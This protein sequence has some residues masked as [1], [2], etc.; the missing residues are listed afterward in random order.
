MNEERAI[1][2]FEDAKHYCEENHPEE[3]DW[4]KSISPEK[5]KHMKSKSFLM[6]YCWVVYVSGFRVATIEERFSDL[7]SAFKEFELVDLARMRSI[8][9]VLAVFNNERKAN[10]FLEGS[11]MIAKEGFSAFKKR[12]KE[13]GID[14]L[15]GL[16]GIGPITKYHLAKNIGLVDE[17][18]PDIWLARAAQE[19]SSTVQDLAV[20]D[21]VAFL[22]EKYSMS[23]HAV[24][25]ILWRYGVDKKL[26]L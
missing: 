26:G 11:K 4:A 1:K 21:L 9:P 19:C 18:K 25:V 12:L 15:E 22:S 5:F 13:Q 14:A 23:R 8:K 7:R 10:S 24:D 3:I 20:Q 16:P 2:L 17:A 6:E